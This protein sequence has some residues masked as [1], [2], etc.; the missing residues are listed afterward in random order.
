M[1][2]GWLT[3]RV[4]WAPRAKGKA[5]IQEDGK[6][7]CLKPGSESS[8]CHQHNFPFVL[9]LILDTSGKPIKLEL[10]CNSEWTRMHFLECT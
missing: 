2:D 4:Q 3:D 5:E 10:G 1:P 7:S 8:E 9:T 6:T